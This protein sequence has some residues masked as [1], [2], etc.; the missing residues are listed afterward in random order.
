MIL[1]KCT[2]LNKKQGLRKA[3]DAN[4]PTISGTEY[5]FKLVRKLVGVDLMV[6]TSAVLKN[7]KTFWPYG[8]IFETSAK[9][10]AVTPFDLDFFCSVFNSLSMEDSN[11]EIFKMLKDQFIL[12]SVIDLSNRKEF[13][14]VSSSL[15]F[16]KNKV[17]EYLDKETGT[18][19]SKFI[20]N[21]REESHF[22]H[23]EVIFENKIKIKP[24]AF[25]G[26][27]SS[28]NKFLKN[29]GISTNLKLCEKIYP[30]AE[31]YFKEHEVVYK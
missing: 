15:S 3:L 4:N 14:S 5:T 27:G 1:V 13:Q 22:P 19:F 2:V 10:K 8:L 25:F 11:N 21:F 28:I 31:A 16:L 30:I 6:H 20:D 23:N 29:A 12:D 26:G 17:G 24:L 7:Y 18:K 9:P